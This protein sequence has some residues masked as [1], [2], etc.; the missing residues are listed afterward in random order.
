MDKLLD[1]EVFMSFNIM[2]KAII[3]IHNKTVN[4]KQENIQIDTIDSIY[5]TSSLFYSASLL[6]IRALSCGLTENLFTLNQS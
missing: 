5:Q 2:H 3:T 4:N 1:V 6:S